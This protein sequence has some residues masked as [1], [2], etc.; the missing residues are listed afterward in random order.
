MTNVSVLGCGYWGPNLVRNLKS[1]TGCRV[2]KV[3]DLRAERLAYLKD[4][5]PDVEVTQDFASVIDSEDTDALVIATPIKT[6]YPLAR[7]ALLAGKHVFVEKPLATSVAECEE[8]LSLAKARSLVIMVGHTFVYSPTV[9]KIK[10]V[11][12]SGDLGEVIYISSRR[13]NLGLLQQDMN[14]AWDLAPHDISIILYVLG[15][16]PLSVNCQG[17]AHVNP[18]VEDVTN[19]T[20]NFANGGFAIIHNSWIDPRK[21]RET[22]IVGTRKMLVY[23]DIEP[24]DKMR[25]FDKCVEIPPHYDTFAE[26]TYSY[27]YGDMYVPYIKQVEPLKVECQS[28]VD[29]I[30]TGVASDSDGREGLKVVRI[31]VAAS[32][33][34]KNNGALVELGDGKRAD[35]KKAVTA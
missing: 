28:F 31:L 22:T 15:K 34:L 8:L 32:E 4:M 11:V 5:H 2:R 13:L 23:D 20:L 9:R 24:L 6:H 3:C 30:E 18:N 17:K 16:M 12:A 19:I 25:I 1:A 33:S 26:F 10:E 29:S 27:H 7:L 14:V 35:G 21:V